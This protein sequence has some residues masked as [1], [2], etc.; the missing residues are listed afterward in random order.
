MPFS[1]DV[2]DGAAA[3]YERERDRYIKL[4][5]RVA[6]MCQASIIEGDAVRAQVT[7]RTKTPQSFRNKLDRFS[8]RPDRN[9]TT[10]DEVF[11]VDGISDFAGVRIATYRPEDEERVRERVCELF[12]GP[13]G[14][15]VH[16]DPKNKLD[17]SKAQFYRATHCQVFLREEDLAG[18][19]DNLR[20]ASCE[21]Q[22]CSMMTHVWNEIEH[23]IG[24]KPDG[25]GPD[26][27]ERGLLEAL[28]HLTRSGDATITR[29]LEANQQRLRSRQGEF[30]DVHDFVAR[31]RDRFPRADLSVNAG[32][33]YDAA[34][35]LG[36]KSPD[37]FEAELG[38]AALDEAAA[39]R[40]IEDFNRFAR[41]NA[42]SDATMNAA[43]AD[44]LTVGLLPKLSIARA[45][46]KGDG[47]GRLKSGRLALLMDVWREMSEGGSPARAAG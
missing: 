12:C 46:D 23:D 19:Y 9:Y 20:G 10:V 17:P 24:Y 32:Q 14:G 13:D 31:L 29:L 11:A 34:Q 39:R 45:V 38:A 18:I 33:A 43:S 47:A 41:E 3:R 8:R 4:A 2:I 21:V 25:G 6:D 1:R 7:S 36:L 42:R 22:I 40:A 27:A 28:G 35:R 30:S 5:G 16:V 26:S 44:L 15:P 37:A